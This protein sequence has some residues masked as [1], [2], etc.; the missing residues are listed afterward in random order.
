MTKVIKLNPY[1]SAWP[2]VFEIESC[3]IK[4]VLGEICIDIHHVGSTSIPQIAA[5]P[6]IDILCVVNDLSYS[7]I[8]QEH[9]FVYKGELN[10]PMA[11][12]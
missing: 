4:Q 8:L 5:K 9:G 11:F 10:I 6:D 2:K 12:G 3:F 7:L 1:N